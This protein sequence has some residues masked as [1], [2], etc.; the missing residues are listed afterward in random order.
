MSNGTKAASITAI[1]G[2]DLAVRPGRRR[3][4]RRVIE[5]MIDEALDR[6][7]APSEQRAQIYR[8]RNRALATIDSYLEDSDAARCPLV[9]AE[10]REQTRRCFAGEA[11][12]AAAGATAAGRGGDRWVAET[13]ARSVRDAY[14]VLTPSQRQAVSDYVRDQ[15]GDRPIAS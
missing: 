5:A 9:E 7:H 2:A 4:A 12:A 6:A 10:L 15:L 14:A 8:V 3:V 1:A 13:I 11:A